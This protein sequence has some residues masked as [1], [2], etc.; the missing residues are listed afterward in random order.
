[1]NL[2]SERELRGTREKLR[3]LEE[4]YGA[5]QRPKNSGSRIY[6]GALWSL[7]RLI[8]QLVEEIVRCEAHLRPR[9][10]SQNVLAMRSSVLER[11]KEYCP[12]IPELNDNGNLPPGIH[13][14]SLA[15]IEGRFGKST[16][17]RRAQMQSLYWLADLAKRAGVE[18]LIVN[19]SFV[20]DV[21][22][23]ND[24]DC[25]V[26]AVRGFPRDRR[27]AREMR[28]GLPFI[29]L[30]LVRRRRF[31]YFVNVLFATDNQSNAKGVI[32]VT[33]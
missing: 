27:A 18:R 19:G 9:D 7:K 15:E 5:A 32:E 3:M 4:H 12:M 28:I 1:M 25:V 24:V 14:A 26:L 30:Q 8:N 33:L 22:E 23:P 10:D 6:E 20:T 31:D 11:P 2:Q 29:H 17:I 13:R 16:E 21:F